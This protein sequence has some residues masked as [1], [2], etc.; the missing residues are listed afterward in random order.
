MPHSVE[1]AAVVIFAIALV[2]TFAVAR[3]E[4]LG[5]RFPRHSGIFHF[6]SEVEVVFGFWALAL[7]L[8][9]WALVGS[10]ATVGYL[11]KRNFTEAL[12]VFVIMV[13][14]ASRPILVLVTNVV[15]WLSRFLP[16]R[17]EVAVVWFSLSAIPLLGSLVTEPAAMTLG[18]LLSRDRLFAVQVPE[19][20]KYFGLALLFV[21]VSIGGVMTAYA[22]PPVLMVANAWGWNTGFMASTFGWKA[23]LAVI[24][25]ATV[26]VAIAAKSIP[27]Q[28]TTEVTGDLLSKRVP[29]GVTV[30]HIAFL[31]LVVTNSHHAVVFIGAFLFF[32]GYT[33]AYERHQSPLMLRESLLVAFFLGGLVVLGGLQ[34]WWLQPV[35][36]SMNALTLYFGATGLTAV[37]DNA[38]ITYLGSL[39]PGLSDSAKYLLVAGAVT[40][41]GL[42]VVANAPNPAGLAILGSRFSGGAVS[43]LRLLGAA[44]L[45]TIT[46]GVAFLIL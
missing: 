7:C 3:I 2:H 30:V 34:Q 26:F 12:F 38:A 16:L 20:V 35:V 44:L 31:A 13:I 10:K 23:A 1:V 24:F 43:P 11:E 4:M 5:H 39:I 42:T 33:Q 22:A 18:A 46:A 25:N 8:V 6:L 29:V 27:S 37:M 41:G 17:A 21:N 14:A 15:M 32:L 28:P 40:G 19:R 45:P 36:G 9:M